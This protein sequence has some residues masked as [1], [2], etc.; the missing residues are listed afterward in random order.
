MHREEAVGM[1]G[2]VCEAFAPQGQSPQ[3]GSPDPTLKENVRVNRSLH[4]PNGTPMEKWRTETGESQE[5]CGPAG[6]SKAAGK[7]LH[8]TQGRK[9]RT[10]WSLVLDLHMHIHT[11]K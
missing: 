9:A 5:A 7:R 8:L 3:F 11:H 1:R 2:S 10:Y 6:L 4:I